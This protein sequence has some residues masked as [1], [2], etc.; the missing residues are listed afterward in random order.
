[1]KFTRRQENKIVADL[2]RLLTERPGDWIDSRWTTSLVQPIQNTG[3]ALADSLQFF[4]SLHNSLEFWTG[5]GF[6]FFKLYRP[7][8]VKF[9]LMNK[10]RLW[11]AVK[12]V[13]RKI[14]ADQMARNVDRLR[15]AMQMP[16]AAETADKVL[17]A[18]TINYTPE[19][20]MQ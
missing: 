16:P 14:A 8:I 9:R 18:D 7:I 5:N 10:L 4:S 15:T 3:N 11:R 12:A 2:L 19:G 17:D 1:M 6:F 20:W 13:R